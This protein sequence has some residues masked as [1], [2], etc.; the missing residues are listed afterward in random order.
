MY[1][2]RLPDLDLHVVELM[3]KLFVRRWNV[4]LAFNMR[5]IFHVKFY[6][7]SNHAHVSTDIMPKGWN[8]LFAGVLI[9]D[10]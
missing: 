4:I 9:K 6:P 10:S 5:M 3:I 7:V 2:S 1:M 8:T